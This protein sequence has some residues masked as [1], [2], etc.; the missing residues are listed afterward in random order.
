MKKFNFT[1]QR[2]L[3]YNIHMQKKEKDNL[4]E[5]QYEYKNLCNK[6]EH[7]LDKYNNYKK[8]QHDESIEGITV[9]D[10]IILNTYISGL[11][12]Q[13]LL[14]KKEM[15]TMELKIEQQIQTL[16]AVTKEKTTLEKLRNKHLNEYNIMERK[17]EELFIDE[18]VANKA[19]N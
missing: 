6:M 16:L 13:I 4:S 8:R 9:T 18:F 3:E 19:S 7:L 2:V 14:L 10:L 1:L 12:T 15:I 5:M 17:H 11:Q